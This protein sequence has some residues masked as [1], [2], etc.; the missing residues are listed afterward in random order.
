METIK[1]WAFTVCITMVGAALFSM[2]VPKG[3][4][5]K[6]VQFTISLFFLVSIVSPL[7]QSPLTLDFES[8]LGSYDNQSVQA[9][10][11]N[12]ANEQIK[13]LAAKKTEDVV[14][15]KL[16]EKNVQPEKIA[17]NV[18]IN[19]DGSICINDISIF[20]YK[21]NAQEQKNLQTFIE[22][23]LEIETQV[24]VENNDS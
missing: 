4:M 7:I 23:E 6:T 8:L 19:E 2:L 12:T 11:E 9:N 20:L 10:V 17:V 3:S 15:E 14:L 5:K 18:N 24:F 13:S 1:E 16:K 21:E 22:S